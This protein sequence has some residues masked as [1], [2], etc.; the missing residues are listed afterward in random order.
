MSRPIK[1]R[2]WDKEFGM[3]ND[4]W[5]GSMSGFV[6]DKD[7]STDL[8]TE[9]GDQPVLMQ[10]TG[11]HDKDGKEIYEGDILQYQNNK[12]KWGAVRAPV[13]FRSGRFIVEQKGANYLGNP[14]FGRRHAVIGNI[15]ENPELSN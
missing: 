4:F 7:P 13:I 6:Y 11:L 8:L 5:V 14:S 15:Y 12:G 2:A 9:M 3:I 10:F 1:F